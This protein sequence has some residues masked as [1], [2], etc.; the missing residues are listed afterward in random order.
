VS[1]PK[2]S[3][4]LPSLNIRP[5]LD[6][7][8]ESIVGQTFT[9]WEA[10]VLDSFS[11]DGSWEV[12]ESA[13]AADARFRLYKT[14]PDGLWAALNRGIGMAKGEFLHIATGDDTMDREFL[15]RLVQ[16]FEI[17]PQAGIA[18]CD[19][20]L[21]NGEGETLS[22]EDMAP[23]LAAESIEDML[24]LE[25]VRS[26]PMIH[27]LNYRPTPHDC[28]LH[29]SA[30]S[31]YLS[32]TQLLIRTQVAAANGPF[33]TTVGSISDVGW[34]ARLTN[35]AG[36][37][38]IPEKLAAWRFRGNQLSIEADPLKLPALMRMLATTA[39]ELYERHRP[40]LSRNDRAAILLPCR[41]YLAIS[42]VQRVRCWMEIVLRAALM[43]MEKPG[44]TLRAMAATNFRPGDVRRKF[45][46]MFMQRL[47]FRPSEIQ[48]ARGHSS[49][50]ISSSASSP[51][52]LRS[53]VV[54][55]QNL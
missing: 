2:V 20:R 7:R 21:I 18:A 33:D 55:D 8:I 26:Y 29:F 53:A 10:I 17:C 51:S 5:Y 25:S 43:I 42:A 41:R 14:P 35:S 47:D 45:L 27:G 15:A 49:A 37:V 12:L 48:P 4:L 1:A 6:E 13:A 34:L 9:D 24:A 32:L 11:T 38:H 52:D 50:A 3:I 22:R 19:V 39:A 46:P 44:S 31:V 36:T 40:L 54:T 28:L 23:Y 16:A 30:K